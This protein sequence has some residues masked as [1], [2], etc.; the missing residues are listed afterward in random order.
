MLAIF[1]YLWVMM[2][3]IQE[4]LNIDI[5]NDK[6]NTEKN[7]TFK[8]TTSEEKDPNHPPYEERLDKY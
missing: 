1:G 6:K 2:S 4:V 8:K 5:S 3:P 7:K